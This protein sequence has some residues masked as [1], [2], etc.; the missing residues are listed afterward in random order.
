[1]RYLTLV[2]HDGWTV[3]WSYLNHQG[4]IGGQQSQNHRDCCSRDVWNFIYIR[5][6]KAY[7][8]FNAQKTA[9]YVF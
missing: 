1:M 5:R 8:V 2:Q 7:G 9:I 6:D 3:Y 4:R